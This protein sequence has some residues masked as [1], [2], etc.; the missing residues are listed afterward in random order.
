M[1]KHLLRFRRTILPIRPSLVA[2]LVLSALL[3]GALAKGAPEPAEANWRV[4]LQAYVERDLRAIRPATSD[5]HDGPPR[6]DYR[7]RGAQ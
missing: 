3:P 5:R 4:S 2:A 7:R 1:P 6:L